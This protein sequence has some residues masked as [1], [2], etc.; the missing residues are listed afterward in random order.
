VNKPAILMVASTN[1][2]TEF[3]SEEL[4]HPQPTLTC[5]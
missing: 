5:R 4:T 1:V 3:G 2:I